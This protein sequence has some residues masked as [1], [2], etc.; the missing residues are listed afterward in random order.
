MHADRA[1][2]RRFLGSAA[3]T[4]GSRGL[5]VVF[6]LGVTA[7]LAR[8]LDPPDYGLLGMA[9]VIIGLVQQARDFGIGPALVQRETV[10]EE[11][12]ARAFTLAAGLSVGLLA[13]CWLVAPAAARFYGEPRVTSIIRVMALG[14]PLTALQVVPLS[15]LR[16]ELRLKG[17]AVARTLSQ[18][19][20]SGLTITLAF[21][22]YGVWALVVGFLAN[23]AVF[24]AVLAV[25]HP[26]RPGLRLRGAESTSLMRFGGGVTLSSFFWYMYSN[27]DFLVVGRLL[28]PAALG[29]YT[30]AWNLAKM[31]WDQIWIALSP[32]ALPLFSRTRERAEGM[33]SALVRLSRGLSLIT[34]PALGGL[35]LVSGEVVPVFLGEKWTASIAPMRWLCLYGM[36]RS[37]SVLLSPV[38]LAGG[39]LRREIGFNLAC[40]AVLPAAFWLAADSGIAAVAACWAMLYPILVAAVILRP[41]L[42]VARTGGGEFMRTLARPAVAT[43]IMA[44]AVLAVGELPGLEP[45]LRLLLKVAT[46]VLAYAAALWLVEGRELLDHARQL[47]QDLRAG[48][49]S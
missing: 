3:W 32:M 42:A 39:R 37:V 36:A 21:N 35:A 13:F 14:F 43:L 2:R 24:A 46:G 19:V 16:R 4:G 45:G 40:V 38:L 8:L 20:D 33:R 18:V 23:G 15:L 47:W 17:E 12:C 25:A 48:T 49:R 26:W 5:M 44:L 34:F 31:P 30:M 6:G 1:L 29:A 28:G 9:M 27:A 22:G 7:V 11:T 41:A 10:T